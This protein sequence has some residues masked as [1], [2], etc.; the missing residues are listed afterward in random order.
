MALPATE[1][2]TDSDGVQLT[3]HS[4]SWTLNRGDFDIYSNALASDDGGQNALSFAHWNADSFDNDQY[5]EADVPASITP[6]DYQIIGVAVRC[7]ASA[8]TAYCYSGCVG[9]SYLARVVAGTATTIADNGDGFDATDEIRLEANGTTVTPILN[10]ST[11]SSLGAQTDATI[12][13]G[14][15]GV[16]SWQETGN[17]TRRNSRVDNWEGGNLGAAGISIPVAMHHYMHQ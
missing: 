3:T 1:A 9:F 5:A 11:D 7:A 14:Y 15:A 13:S 16:C 8:V 4:A 2:F 12:A 17:T 10:G 6:G